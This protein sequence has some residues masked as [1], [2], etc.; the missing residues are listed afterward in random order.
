MLPMSGHGSQYVGS[1][2]CAAHRRLG[3]TLHGSSNAIT[4]ISG[5]PSIHP[6]RLSP[7]G[8]DSV[9]VQVSWLTYSGTVVAMKHVHGRE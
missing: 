8:G 7:L 1:I 5:N 6:R 9:Y 2:H 4:F 3:G